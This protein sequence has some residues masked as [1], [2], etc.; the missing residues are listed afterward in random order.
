MYD[1]CCRFGGGGNDVAPLDDV[2][3]VVVAVAPE[4]TTGLFDGAD[5][6]PCTGLWPGRAG[7]ELRPVDPPVFPGL[8]GGGGGGGGGRLAM[9]TRSTIKKKCQFYRTRSRKWFG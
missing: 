8:G 6:L 9:V 4:G 3:V 5:P 2:D 7:I 1:G